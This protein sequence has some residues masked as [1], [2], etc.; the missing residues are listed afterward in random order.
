MVLPRNINTLEQKK[1]KEA[2]G[3]VTVRTCLNPEQRNLFQA[4]KTTV[5][6]SATRIEFP[7]EGTEFTLYHVTA[8]TNVFLGGNDQITTT[9]SDSAALPPEFKLELNV[10]AGNDNNIYG[11][12]ASGTVDV[13]V[14]GMLRE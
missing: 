13:Y 5:G 12:V 11:V 6:T 8:A 14:I 7:E 4:L 10:V 2:N 9:S 3:K 1:F